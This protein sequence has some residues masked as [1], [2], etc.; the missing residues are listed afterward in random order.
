MNNQ[1]ELQLMTPAELDQIFETLGRNRFNTTGVDIEYHG[2]VR[3]SIMVWSGRPTSFTLYV[4][5]EEAEFIRSLNIGSKQDLE[6]I[7]EKEL[8]SQYSKGNGCV[9]ASLEFD[10]DLSLSFQVIDGVT[11]IEGFRIPYRAEI[12]EIWDNLTPFRDFVRDNIRDIY[13]AV[14]KCGKI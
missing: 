10:M 14:E 11:V 13:I 2:H 12:I 8:W 3:A 7:D 6:A 9:W 1:T 5:Q 4:E